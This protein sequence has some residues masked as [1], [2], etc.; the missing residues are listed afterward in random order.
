MVFKLS[1]Y[2]SKRDWS[3]KY[4]NY[5]E[6]KNP[7]LEIS[8][9]IFD[10]NA[11]FTLNFNMPVSHYVIAW[12][13]RIVPLNSIFFLF[14]NV[15]SKKS[16]NRRLPEPF[17]FLE[18]VYRRCFFLFFYF[19]SFFFFFFFFCC[20]ASESYAFGTGMELVG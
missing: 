4:W 10:Q 8:I 1:G 14:F 13:P 6:R 5:S 19:I 11:S 12:P 3:S 15:P 16:F 2:F 20:K 17:S 7:L 9:V 18:H